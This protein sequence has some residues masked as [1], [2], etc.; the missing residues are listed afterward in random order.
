MKAHFPIIKRAGLWL[1]FAVLLMLASAAIFYINFRPSIQFTGGAQL[2]VAW[3]LSDQAKQDI[4]A[5]PGVSQ[6]GLNTEMINN[7]EYTIVLTQVTSKDDVEITKISKAVQDTL[8]T[9][10]HI[11]DSGKIM[12]SSIVWPSIGEYLTKS[13][14]NTILIGL[15]LIAIYMVFSFAEVRRYIQPQ[16][17]A[18]ITIFTML[19]DVLAPMW[20]YG[21]KMMIDPTT[22]VDVIFVIALLTT[23]GYSINDTIVIFDRIRENL[24]NLWS[25]VKDIGQLF[26]DSIWQT[27]RR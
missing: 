6:V 24:T 13:A 19:F 4:L 25:K 17:L 21:I 8:I 2:K 26:E 18:A 11:T 27:M 14:R 20:V 22:Q 15:F 3:Q 9:K 1:S 5:I 23:M 7:Q 10:K 12:E 16:V